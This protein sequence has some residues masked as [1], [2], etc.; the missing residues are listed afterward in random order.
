MTKQYAS[1]NMDGLPSELLVRHGS[2]ALMAENDVEW[3]VA[4]AQFRVFILSYP[5]NQAHTNEIPCVVQ[6]GLLFLLTANT[7]FS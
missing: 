4:P 1:G 7:F 5:K 2:G 3:I 6:L